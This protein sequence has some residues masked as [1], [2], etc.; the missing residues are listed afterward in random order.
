MLVHISTLT[1]D[2]NGFGTNS[3]Q[4]RILVWAG[5][6]ER[7]EEEGRGEEKDINSGYGTSGV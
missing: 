3:C 2:E 7:Q 5:G 4:I 1:H 6:K